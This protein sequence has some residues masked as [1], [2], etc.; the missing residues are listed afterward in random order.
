MC[1]YNLIIPAAGSCLALSN[2]PNLLKSQLQCYQRRL[3]FRKMPYNALHNLM[4]LCSPARCGLLTKQQNT[5]TASCA[6]VWQLHLS[7]QA[8]QFEVPLGFQLHISCK[9]DRSMPLSLN[10]SI[11]LNS[12]W[13]WRE[14]GAASQLSISNAWPHI[15]LENSNRICS[16]LDFSCSPSFVLQKAHFCFPFCSL[17]LDLWSPPQKGC[18]SLSRQCLAQCSPIIHAGKMLDTGIKTISR[19]NMALITLLYKHKK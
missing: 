8:L 18:H 2:Y 19:I 1:C 3:Y 12:W 15:T 17:C 6:E 7:C 5:I 10:T 11:S 4:R 16:F 9:W 13:S 14:L